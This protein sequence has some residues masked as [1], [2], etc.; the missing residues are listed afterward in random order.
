MC[1][2]GIKAKQCVKQAIYTSNRGGNVGWNHEGI[3]WFNALVKCIKDQRQ[4][5]KGDKVEKKV[6]GNNT[7]NPRGDVDDERPGDTEIPEEVEAAFEIME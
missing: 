3:K 5:G 1:L 6:L 4:N 7:V 2:R